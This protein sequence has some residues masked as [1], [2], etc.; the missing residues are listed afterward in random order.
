M[1]YSDNIENAVQIIPIL[2]N[3]FEKYIKK[4][5]E[6][7]K[8]WLIANDFKANCGDLCLLAD[9]NG[10]LKSVYIGIEERN[11]ITA[12]A[13]IALKLPAGIYY[14]D[15]KISKEVAIYWGLAQYKFL[16]YKKIKIKRRVLTLA[17]NQLKEVRAIFESIVLIRDLINTPTEDLGPEELSFELEKLA[18][19]FQADFSEVV[20]NDL[21]ALNFPAIYVVGRASNRD[22][23]LLRMSWGNAKDPLICLVGKGVCFDTGGLD[24]KPSNGMRNMKKDMGG[25]A[26]VIGLAKLIMQMNLPIRIEVIIPAVENSVAGNSYRPGDVIQ[27]R[28]GLTVEIGNTDAE[29]RLVLADAL[30]L[31]SELKPKLILDFA[32][33]TGAARVALGLD[34]A[35]MFS[36]DNLIA[37]QLQVLGEKFDDPIWQLPLYNGYKKSIQ[38]AIADLSTTGDSPFGGAITAALFLEFFVKSKTPWVHFDI[39]AWNNLTR[40]G[41]PQGGEA[42]AI[43]SVYEFLKHNFKKK[44]KSKK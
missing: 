14:V 19:E 17:T 41:K 7:I 42:L 38:P 9:K 6:N 3:N 5:P 16:K 30:T 13:S 31:A 1:F 44:E 2:K 8:N 24:L 43:R 39:M 20:G 27:T 23:R 37:S 22:P 29:G 11:D 26:H 28:Q 32:T 10:K 18:E 12:F 33:L 25:A 15:S 40:V 35:A 21:M 34:V 4:E 36:N